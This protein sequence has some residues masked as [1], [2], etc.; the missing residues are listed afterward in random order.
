MNSRRQ[1]FPPLREIIRHKAFVPSAIFVALVVILTLSSRFA[2]HPPI[3]ENIT[4]QVGYPGMVLLIKGNYF[5]AVRGS[6][7]VSFSGDRPS[8]S[9]Y[10]QWTNRRISVRVPENATSGFVFVTKSNGRSN[11]VLFT[12]KSSLPVIVSAGPGPGL[13][14]IP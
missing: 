7:E 2:D 11:G 6:S 10:L 8:T 3:I 12:N 1:L 13:P 5:G 9:A 4:P 14:F